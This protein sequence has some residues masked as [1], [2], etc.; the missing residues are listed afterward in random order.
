[1]I[2]EATAPEGF[3][4]TAHLSVA[5]A[6]D[7]WLRAQT[8][9]DRDNPPEPWFEFGGAWRG[10]RIRYRSCVQHSEEFNTLIRTRAYPDEEDQELFGF[11][12]TGLASIESLFHGLYSLGWMLNRTTGRAFA[13]ILDRQ[14]EI[15]PEKTRDAFRK[16]Y[17]ASNPLTKCLES[18]LSEP[19][20]KEWRSIRNVLAHRAAPPRNIYVGVSTGGQPDPSTD[21]FH[22][23]SRL[24]VL[25][26]LDEWTTTTRLE[27][28]NKQLGVL[29]RAAE[30]FADSKIPKK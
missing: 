16:I 6:V 26:A 10:V 21:F 8:D 30:D 9:E 13:L 29:L 12:V 15:S 22:V 3:L 2:D 14:E 27:W 23:E 19:K 24:K 20:M 28:L 17:G 7:R 25:G 18:V 4:S 1:M 11:F 5:V